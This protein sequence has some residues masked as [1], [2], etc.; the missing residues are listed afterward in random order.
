MYWIDNFST[1]YKPSFKRFFVIFPLLF[2][3]SGFHLF[4]IFP[5]SLNITFSFVGLSMILIDLR[6]RSGAVS[7]FAVSWQSWSKVELIQRSRGK[8]LCL[9]PFEWQA[10]MSNLKSSLLSQNNQFSNYHG[11]IRFHQPQHFH[12]YFLQDHP[13]LYFLI[14]SIL[15]LM[16]RCSV[17]M[18]SLHVGNHSS[19][20]FT[21]TVH[22]RTY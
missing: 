12:H 18:A 11:R 7:V 1:K 21:V 20:A 9:Q 2:Y 6:N 15:I 8:L 3:L 16:K 17:L 4:F 10:C 13:P 14:T 5:P 19:A 22:W